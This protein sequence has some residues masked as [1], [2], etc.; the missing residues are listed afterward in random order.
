MNTKN[1]KHK[2]NNSL[3]PLHNELYIGFFDHLH[4]GHINLLSINPHAA[5]LTFTNIPRKSASIYPLQ[6]RIDDLKSLG[7]KDIY[8]YDIASNNLT[9]EAFI[10]DVLMKNDVT[11]VLVGD[12]CKIGS[13]QRYVSEFSNLIPMYVLKRNKLSTTYIKKLLS[14]GKVKKANTKTY[15]PYEV[16][17]VV[18]KANQRGRTIG[19]PTANIKEDYP[20][21]LKEGVYQTKIMIDNSWFNS[22]TFVGKTKTF[23][24]NNYSIET[25]IFNFDRDIYQ[26]HIKLQFINYVDKVRSFSNVDDLKKHIGRLVKKTQQMF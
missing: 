2:N 9:A 22:I 7:F 16:S 17:G 13:D 14:E 5:V 15:Q 11:K 4:L 8:V 12:D 25:Y 24:E 18:I 3:V 26:K 23:K 19:Y 21:L 20:C 1:N 6:K 10:K